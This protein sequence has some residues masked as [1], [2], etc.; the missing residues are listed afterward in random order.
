MISKCKFCEEP[1][2]NKHCVA[3]DPLAPWRD[4]KRF[5]TQ[6][7]KWGGDAGDT[8]NRH[9]MMFAFNQSIAHADN[10]GNMYEWP[11]VFIHESGQII[12][13]PYG[14]QPWTRELNRS[15]RDQAT[16]WIAGLVMN[17]QFEDLSSALTR[18]FLAVVKNF[19]RFHNYKKN[20]RQERV[21]WYEVDL[22]GPDIW[23]MFL[24]GVRLLKPISFLRH[25]TDIHLLIDTCLWN[26][27]KPESDNDIPQHLA[28]LKACNEVMPTSISKLALSLLNKEKAILKVKQYYDFPGYSPEPEKDQVPIGE[29]IVKWLE[30]Q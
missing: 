29:I 24:R 7:V 3:A 26:W 9:G 16:P 19:S 13:H 30:K 17:Q 25:I 15:S 21:K 14:L 12:R 18:I 27:A 11:E 4:E 6:N 8:A 23:S 1:C 20:G 5:I 22:A 2:G 10:L 28:I